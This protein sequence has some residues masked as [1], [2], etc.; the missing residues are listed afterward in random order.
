MIQSQR[1]PQLECLPLISF[2]MHSHP[3]GVYLLPIHLCQLIKDGVP[4]IVSEN[5][6]MGNYMFNKKLQT[7]EVQVNQTLPLNDQ[8][9]RVEW[10]SRVQS[11]VYILKGARG[12]FVVCIILHQKRNRHLITKK[13]GIVHFDTKTPK[14]RFEIVR[15]SW[16]RLEDCYAVLFL[17]SFWG[18]ILCYSRMRC[19]MWWK[20]PLRWPLEKHVNH[21]VWHLPVTIWTGWL[22]FCRSG[23]HSL[24]N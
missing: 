21:W 18:N 4:R 23:W 19:F 16:K 2:K 3:P 9:L 13:T 11:M 22:W 12:D 6:I 7:Q 10:T 1:Q 5:V 8:P 15:D 24:V 17:E 14:T 20:H